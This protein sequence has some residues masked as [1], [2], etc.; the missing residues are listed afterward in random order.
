[1]DAKLYARIKRKYGNCASWAVWP[2]AGLTAKS[3]VGD[4][5]IF[6]IKKN[7]G[8]LEQL[9]TGIILV[10]LNIARPFDGD[11]AN[12]HDGKTKSQDYKLRYAVNGSRLWGAYLTDIIKFLPCTNS[13]DTIKQLRADPSIE[14]KNV[15]SSRNELKDLGASDPLIIALGGETFK[16]LNRNFRHE[17]KIA[18]VTHYSSYVNIDNLR[19]EYHS[20]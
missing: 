2:E 20:L 18:K 6:D 19:N 4:L 17:F 11:F 1:M 3:N 13:D 10:G 15:E 7:I 8:L 9:N 12:F 5:D 14:R 16:I